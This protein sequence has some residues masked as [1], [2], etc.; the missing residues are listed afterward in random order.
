MEILGFPGG[1][2]KVVKAAETS[3]PTAGMRGGDGKKKIKLRAGGK[4]GSTG[5]T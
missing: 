2:K 1:E 5:T 4:L 3:E